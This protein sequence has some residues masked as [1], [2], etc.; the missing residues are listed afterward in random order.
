MVTMHTF[1]LNFSVK[2]RLGGLDSILLRIENYI[3]L[4]TF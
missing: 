4:A 3:C 1:H 2:F